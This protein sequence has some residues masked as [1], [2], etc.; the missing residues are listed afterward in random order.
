MR[1]APDC[2]GP[3]ADEMYTSA[4]AEMGFFPSETIA[5][6][7]LRSEDSFKHVHNFMAASLYRW[8]ACAGSQYTLH[9]CIDALDFLYAL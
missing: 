4:Q 1:V 6:N 8:Q 7:N 2:R 3:D 5:V 9:K